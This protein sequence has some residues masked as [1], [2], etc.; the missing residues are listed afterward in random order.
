MNYVVQLTNISLKPLYS[1]VMDDL[2]KSDKPMKGYG[3]SMNKVMYLMQGHPFLGF[4]SATVHRM[5]SEK[6]SQE[7]IYLLIC[8]N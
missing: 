2:K 6:H 5:H 7:V 4:L 3:E 8:I 1:V